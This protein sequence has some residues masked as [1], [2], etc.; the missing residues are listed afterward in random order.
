[1]PRLKFNDNATTTRAKARTRTRQQQEERN[2]LA[3]SGSESEQL[4]ASCILQDA[5]AAPVAFLQ[6]EWE[7]NEVNICVMLYANA[8]D[9]KPFAATAKMW[10]QRRDNDNKAGSFR[11]SGCSAS[12]PLPTP[13]SLSLSHS[14]YQVLNAL[15]T[16]SHMHLCVSFWS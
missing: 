6:S 11:L 1:M 2:R 13:I 5:H 9:R 12:I 4:P 7:R 15:A 14:L 3:K 10:Q 8:C 16:F